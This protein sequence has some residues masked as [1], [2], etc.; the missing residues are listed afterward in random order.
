MRQAWT[1]STVST[2]PSYQGHIPVPTYG[3]GFHRTTQ[4]R[5]SVTRM[6]RHEEPKA[7]LLLRFTRNTFQTI[8]QDLLEKPEGKKIPESSISIPVRINDVE[9]TYTMNVEAGKPSNPPTRIRKF[10]SLNPLPAN[11]PPPPAPWI[12]PLYPHSELFE[13]RYISMPPPDYSTIDAETRTLEDLM[14][15][16]M[17]ENVPSPTAPKLWPGNQSM[18]GSG[19][20]GKDGCRGK[21]MN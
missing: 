8:Q 9:D 21:D 7:R 10:A 4:D 19:E 5:G 1:C 11:I 18:L 16:E 20:R 15:V 12:E 6:G 2:A 13:G 14:A 3:Y 17:W